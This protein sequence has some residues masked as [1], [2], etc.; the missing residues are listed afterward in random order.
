MK[1]TL[2]AALLC[3]QPM[4]ATA[5][6]APS[7][8]VQSGLLGV[9]LPAGATISRN[10][11][12]R[13]AARTSLKLD[14]DKAG[15]KLGEALEVLRIPLT[16][17]AQA[18][19][20]ALIQTG[21]WTLTMNQPNATWGIAERAGIRMIV[22]FLDSQRERWIY[23]AAIAAPVAGQDIAMSG[24]MPP[25]APEGRSPMPPNAGY[26]PSAAPEA[27]PA[28]PAPEAPP[29]PRTPPRTASAG[30]G[31]T[32]SISD[33]D[34]GWTAKEYPDHVE[35]T[36]GPVTVLLFYRVEMTAQMRENTSEYFWAR[37]VAPR[38]D[39]PNFARRQD[40]RSV[41]RTEYLEGDATERSTGK[42]AFIG[43]NVNLVSGRALNIVV[44][45]PDMATFQQLFPN[46]NDLE[47]MMPYNS[48]AIGASDLTGHWSSTSSVVT[49]M[50]Y[51]ETGM[52]AG[53]NI[54]S[55]STEFFVNADGSYTSKH[56]GAF[57]MSGT[58]KVYSDTYT[59]RF[60]TN[61]IWE[62]TFTNRFNGK[63]DTFAAEFEIVQGG[64]ILH[65][66]NVKATGIRYHLGRVP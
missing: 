49:Q 16:A 47:R 9:E 37:D 27:S 31:F 61:G 18:E 6:P 59:G 48:F 57:G 3:L 62:V 50:V 66:T 5:Q 33:F 45:A 11:I 34:D 44:I 54:N 24:A 32:Y 63:A 14:A 19:L 39:A 35:V 40:D 41:Y 53:M 10:G 42:Q 65:L 23:V 60:S 20:V 38:F 58:T 56:V 1:T 8:P 51:R 29:A 25:Q 36:K 21:G 7:A 55:S 52:N 2:A 13:W 28:P 64:R 30:H 26:P 4:L 46:P 17:P 15:L 43:M 12:Y 22:E